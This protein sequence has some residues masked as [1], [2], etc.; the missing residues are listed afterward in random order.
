MLLKCASGKNSALVLLA[1]V[2]AFL[3]GCNQGNGKQVS[4]VGAARAAAVSVE[5][6]VIQPQLLRNQ[7]YTTGT[8][9]ANEEVEL[10][11][12]ISGR[13]TDVNF[14]EGKK[15]KKG[16]LLLKIN[17]SELKA[18]LKH[19][20]IEEE[21]ASDEEGRSRK[22]HEINAISQDDYDKV[23]HSLQMVQADKAAIESQITQTEIRAPFDGVIGLRHISEGG[24]VTPDLMLASIQ[25]LD[26]MKVEF[27]VP[28]KYVQQ[29]KAGTEIVIKTGDSQEESRGKVYA[30]E[31]KIDSDTRTIK[32]RAKI[33]NPNAT[34]IP[35]SFAKVEI[36]L[37]E[38]PN[39]IVIPSQAVVPQISGES[40]F[41]CKNGK[42]AMIP[43]KTG[44]RTENS[45]QVIEGLAGDDTLIVSGLMQLADGKGVQISSLKSN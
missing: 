30:V 37:E 45:V 1:L 10:R 41:I 17:D 38:L 32:A 31:S 26:P 44:I 27:S 36:T 8:L 42:A 2:V 18:Q 19:K 22:L 23:L 40:V 4:R 29:L 39:A 13:V 9:M 14:E 11:S 6:L 34:L 15:V 43:V 16:D 21:Q 5:A 35:G 25:E 24:Y 28:E 12:E 20:E 3:G 33:P 7:I